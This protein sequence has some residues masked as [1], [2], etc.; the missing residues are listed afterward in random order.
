MIIIAIANVAVVMVCHAKRY[1]RSCYVFDRI[2]LSC[3]AIHSLVLLF[4]RCGLHI[5][6]IT[7]DMI[8]AL[9]VGMVWAVVVFLGSD[10]VAMVLAAMLSLWIGLHSLASCQ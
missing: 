8:D 5:T 10:A 7:S 9:D 6:M 1:T 2:A 3:Q 4:G